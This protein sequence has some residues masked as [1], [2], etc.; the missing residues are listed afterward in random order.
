MYSGSSRATGRWWCAAR[1]VDGWLPVGHR[2]RGPAGS[3]PLHRPGVAV[4]RAHHAD[5]RRR[6][7]L[8]AGARHPDRRVPHQIGPAPRH[9]RLQR[10]GRCATRHGSPD[11]VANLVLVSCEAFDEYPP[12]TPGRL[13]CRTAALPGG[14]FLTAQLL[15]PLDPP[16][17]RDL[18][19]PAQAAGSRGP[20]PEL[21]PSAAP[22]PQGPPRPS[23]KPSC[24]TY[25]VV[26]SLTTR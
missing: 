4:R 22:Q 20:L 25:N 10:L 8:P 5:A 13:L 24:E 2:H 18:R 14:T 12:G 19:R 7:P 17:P 16:S 21:D 3:L 26:S 11:R 9:T 15:R 1:G 23:L 6:R